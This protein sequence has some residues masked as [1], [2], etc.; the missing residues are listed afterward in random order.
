MTNAKEYLEFASKADKS[1]EVIDQ[2]VIYDN[3]TGMP[4]SIE[5]KKGSGV[6]EKYETKYDKLG[7]IT[8]EKISSTYDGKTKELNNTYEYD[9]IGRLSK[10]ILS[11]K[12][13]GK[14]LANYTKPLLAVTIKTSS[15]EAWKILDI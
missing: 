4:T 3:Y 13:D 10:D 8:S 12:K 9:A 5:Y 2:N 11:V 7:Y 14:T 1:G 6:I 15:A